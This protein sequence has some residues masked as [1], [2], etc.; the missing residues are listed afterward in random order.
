LQRICGI[1]ILIG[2]LSAS[3]SASAILGQFTLDGTLIVT[4]NGLTEWAS[5]SSA[6]NEATISSVNPLTGS[7]V[8]LGN[9]TVFIN[10]L[11]DGP[12]PVFDQPVNTP[13]NNYNF[14][15]FPSDPAFPELLANFIPLGTGGPSDCSTNI[16]LAG[17]G[18]TCTLGFAT[19]P[20]APGGSPFTFLNSETS[21]GPTLVCCAS[22]A[23][24]SIGG[25]TS[26]GLSTW[27]AAITF[28]FP[29]PYQQALSN[30]ATNGEVSDAYTETV[31][32]TSDQ[33]AAPEPATM[34]LMGTGLV[35]AWLARRKHKSV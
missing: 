26:D 5:N 15:D 16:A 12:N 6:A 8:G 18:Q 25:V 32:V 33:P 7:F 28:D 34:A 4:S 23:T 35:L 2:S 27:T 17:A 9:Q 13:F 3:L 24:W 31:T 30:L 10:A 19:N 21:A 1:V 22:S 29:F 11:T 14:I 20:S